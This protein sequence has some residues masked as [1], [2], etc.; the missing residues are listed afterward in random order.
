MRWRIRR[1]SIPMHSAMARKQGHLQSGTFL[2]GIEPWSAP[3]TS[4]RTAAFGSRSCFGGAPQLL[5]LRMRRIH[6][7]C[8]ALCLA[9]LAGCAKL[10]E[11]RVTP[12]KPAG[13]RELHDY[14]QSHRD[15]DQ[16]RLQGPFAVNIERNRDL[17]AAGAGR[18]GADLF[19]S[20]VKEK[21]GLAI[22]LHGHASSRD[23]HTFQALHLA[24]WGMHCL[25]LDLPNNGPWDSNGKTAARVVSWI[26]KNPQLIDA[27]IDPA[28]IILIG[29]SFGATSVAV[30]LAD[31]APAS[32]GILLD[33]AAIGR[34]IPA[35]LNRINTPVMIIG[36]DEH[37]TL[38][39]NRGFFYRFVRRGIT[40][41][42]IRDAMHEDAQ[43]P[44]HTGQTTEAQQISF[45]SAIVASSISLLT[46]GKF[47]YAWDSFDEAIQSGRFFNARR[48]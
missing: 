47:D 2:M 11:T 24:S 23:D 46:T 4:H 8:A 41:I 37:L 32:G 29:H 34:N 3:T 42:S 48:K 26:A 10:P 19:L 25:T 12:L 15:V 7:I 31:G 22:F 45:V 18:L 33:P 16:F 39:L 35:F 40:E 14:L 17:G 6:L 20:S 38:T 9:V 44:S 13:L 28:K 1:G 36:A 43:Y 27:R 21:T 5:S 30:A